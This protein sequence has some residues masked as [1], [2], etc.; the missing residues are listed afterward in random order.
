MTTSN[1]ITKK[2]YALAAVAVAF[3]ISSCASGPV[4]RVSDPA[5]SLQQITVQA[6]SSWQVDLRLQNYSSIPMRFENV[7]LKMT[8]D[9]QDAA[10]IGYSAPITIGPESPDVVKVT[11]MPSLAGKALI[12]EAL[13]RRTTLNY[14][15]QGTITA[16][17]DAAKSRVF[18]YSGNSSL[19][20]APGL[21]GV[22]R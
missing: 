10:Y 8:I 13:T 14:K 18:N 19:N 21:S 2:R 12:A 16:S 4:R 11:V 15:L 5:A 1:T 6:D 22:L 17:P 20:P 3:L 7:V 9:G